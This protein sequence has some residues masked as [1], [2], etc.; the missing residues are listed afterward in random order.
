MPGSDPIEATRRRLNPLLATVIRFFFP[1]KI[2]KL[3]N[4]NVSN[5]GNEEQGLW[6]KGLLQRDWL[7]PELQKGHKEMLLRMSD[8]FWI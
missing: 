1:S 7:L 6:K 3:V 5:V 2:K 4:G 8:V